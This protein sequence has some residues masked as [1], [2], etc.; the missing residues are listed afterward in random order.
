MASPTP[1]A[2]ATQ[3]TVR[4]IE[5]IDYLRGVLAFSVLLHHY[6]V[7]SDFYGSAFVYDTLHKLGIYAVSSF[8]VI[9]G[10]SFGYV[11]ARLA[12]TP[13]S[14]AG[15]L[16]KRYF[17]LAPLYIVM[18]GATVVLAGNGL[19]S[20]QSV[21]LNV[22][23][24]FGVVDPANYIVIGG[25]S[26][27][28]E[29]A[30]YLL[31]PLLIVLMR[32]RWWSALGIVAGT[33]LVFAYFTFGVLSVEQAPEVAWPSYINPLNQLL[34]FVAGLALAPLIH[35]KAQLPTWV[36]LVLVVGLVAAFLA[37]PY[38]E[39]AVSIFAGWPRVA[40]T[41]V[42][43]VLCG[44]VYVLPPTPFGGLNG[45]LGFLGKASYSVYIGHGVMYYGCAAVLKRTLPAI[46]PALVA[47]PA[48]LVF[49]YFSY[50]YF[51]V[52]MVTQGKRVA[53][54]V[55]AVIGRRSGTVQDPSERERRTW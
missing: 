16:T 7:W 5:T 12:V 28:N 10:I 41:A 42:C 6:A 18:M 19:P 38:G 49:S 30:F 39:T 54:R 48:T 36:G 46:E 15:F 35:A 32:Y 50:H 26:I 24:L 21:L 4:R 1:P 11:Y 53:K 3:R 34:F 51:E 45:V 33:V 37:L 40:Y 47:I 22:T 17:R 8:Y 25:W 43:I 2:L 13:S 52:P 27:G 44:V 20:I 55:E 23:L 14:V 29:M 9:S 31:F